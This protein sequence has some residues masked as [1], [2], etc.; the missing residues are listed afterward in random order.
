MVDPNDLNSRDLE[1][2]QLLVWIEQYLA[3]PASAEDWQLLLISVRDLG[4]HTGYTHGKEDV[5]AGIY[6]KREDFTPSDP[7]E[8]SD[9]SDQDPEETMS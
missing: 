8:K 1:D 6:G 2:D 4:Y 5:E 7:S 3:A 9:P